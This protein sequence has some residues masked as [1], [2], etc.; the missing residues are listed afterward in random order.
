[1]NIF[2][3]SLLIL[4]TNLV[5]AKAQDIPVKQEDRNTY[6]FNT[7]EAIRI[8]NFEFVSAITTDQPDIYIINVRALTGEN[9]TD[10]TIQGKLLFEING[11]QELVDFREG[12]G[13]V[14]TTIKGTDKITMRDVD[15]HI[16]RVGSI[17]HP[18]NWSKIGG[19]ALVVAVL[20]AVILWRRKKK[21]VS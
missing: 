8:K 16:T 14:R 17:K 9:K 3:I 6:S 13:Q 1:M 10:A 19:L 15:S 12:I 4:I 21:T 18:M 2:F 5:T 11:K 20:A 7:G